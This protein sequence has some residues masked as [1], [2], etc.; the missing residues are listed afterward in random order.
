[1]TAAEKARSGK[2]EW[3]F[4][5]VSNL[6]ICIWGAVFIALLLQMQTTGFVDW[7][8]LFAAT[9]F[10]IYSSITLVLVCFNSVLAGWQI[11]ADY[12]K[13]ACANKIYM[14]VCVIVS[15]AYLAAGNYILWVQ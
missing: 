4:Q 14:L 9:W 5:R 13:V 15:T 12:V 11:A 1:M 2:R 6:A 10:K 8:L 7:Q 3:I